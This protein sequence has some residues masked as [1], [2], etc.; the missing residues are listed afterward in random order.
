MQSSYEELDGQPLVDWLERRCGRRVVERLWKPL[1]DS[2]FDG[3]F[4]DLPATYIW[5]RTRRMGTTRDRSGRE[6]MGWLEGG[7]QTLIDAL[8]RKLSGSAA[9][10]RGHRGGTDHRRPDGGAGGW[11]SRAAPALR[12]RPLHARAPAGPGAPRAKLL[13]LAP[14]DH[15][16]YLGVVCLFLRTSGASARTTTSTSRTEHPTDHHRR[17][18]AR[19]RSRA[20]RRLSPVRHQVRRPVT[21]RPAAAAR[22]GRTRLSRAMPAESSRTC[23]RTRS[24]APFSSAHESRNRCT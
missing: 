19:R 17:D 5:A 18:D 21:P 24:S 2:K 4:E 11:W 15:C 1:L 22:R 3:R 12:L 9:S 20:G 13:E 23:A 10:A 6:V 16:R 8:E 7:Y 14:E